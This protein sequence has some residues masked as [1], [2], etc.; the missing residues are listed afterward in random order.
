VSGPALDEGLPLRDYW[1]ELLPYRCKQHQDRVAVDPI[2]YRRCAQCQ[3]AAQA[4]YADKRDRGPQGYIEMTP[5]GEI[6]GPNDR[7][8]RHE[9]N[10]IDRSKD[11]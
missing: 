3:K 4:G 11:K 9:K 10:F 2:A 5:H 1:G 7:E 8:Q 6:L